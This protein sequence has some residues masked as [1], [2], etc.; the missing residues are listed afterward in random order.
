[1]QV[2]PNKKYKDL[3]QKQKAKICDWMFREVCE[4]YRIYNRMPSD[5]E[6]NILADIV[7][8]KI[9]GAAIWVS[10]DEFLV[11]FQKK[12]I[13]FHERILTAGLPEIQEKKPKQPT[14]KKPRKKKK[15]KNKLENDWNDFQDDRFF[16]IAGYTSGGVPYGITWEEM[17]MN[18]YDDFD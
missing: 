11:I 18:P 9:K 2:N 13:R 15:S 12:L 5:K 6:L 17:G 14:G 10:Y 7:Y 16:F 4:F 3:K 8:I 1:M